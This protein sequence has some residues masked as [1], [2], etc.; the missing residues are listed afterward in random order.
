MFSIHMNDQ[1]KTKQITDWRLWSKENQVMVTVDFPSG[2]SFTKPLEACEIKPKNEIKSG[3]LSSEKGIYRLIENAV[4]YGDKYVVVN[5]PND[6]KNYVMKLENTNIV[7]SSDLK[8]ENI[9]SYFTDIVKERVRLANPNDKSM[10]ENIERQLNKVTPHK[11]T[12]LHAYCYGENQNRNPLE[13]YIFPFGLNESQLEAVENAFSS[14]ISIIEGPPG[15]GK[16]QTILNIIANI[17]INKKSVAIVSNNNGAVENVYE[18]MAKQELDYLVAKLGRSDYKKE[19]FSDLKDVPSC[20]DSSVEILIEEIDEILEK[21]KSVLAAQNKVAKLNTEISELLIE[22]KYLEEWHKE[23]SLV[24]LIDINKYKLNPE[25]TTDLLAYINHLSQTKISF[26][27]RFRLLIEFKMI[28]IKF[29]AT[30]SERINFTYSLQFHYYEKMLHQKEQQLK[31]YENELKRHHFKELLEDL[32]DKSMQYLKQHLSKTIPSTSNFT[33]DNYRKNFSKFIERFPV[34]GSSTHSIINSI[35]DGAILDYIIIDE[36]SQQD[37]VPGILSLGCAKNIIVVGDRKQLPHIPEET[38]IVAPSKYYDCSKYSL[39]DSFVELFKGDVP[40]TLLKEH[41][42]CHPKIIQFCNQQFY[43]NQLIPMTIDNGESSIQLITTAK[44][45]HTR[46]LANLREIESLVEIGWSNEKDIG[47]IAP[48]NNQVNLAG[49]YLPEEFAR[50]TI[51]KFQGRECREIIFST[52]LDKKAKDKLSVEFVDNPHLVN[53]AVSR[54]INKFTL[55]TGEEVFTKN[56]KSL[57]ALIRYIKYYAANEQIYSSPVIS[58]FDLLYEEYDRSLEK[59]NTRLD[60]MNKQVKSEKIFALVLEDILMK[61]PFNSLKYHMQIDLIQLASIKNNSFT[62]REL[63]FMRQK[64]SCDFVIY[65]KVGKNPIGV[66]EVDGSYHDE[67]ETQQER[68]QLKDSILEKSQI[69]LLRVKTREGDIE[70]KTKV[71]LN[72]CIIKSGTQDYRES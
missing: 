32:T 57:A 14:Q 36:A 40:V 16:T 21:L 12:A 24:N 2:K 58:A 39:L 7:A 62:E 48:Y 10:P 15:T 69:P 52:V 35:A 56:N 47:F 4:E 49:K 31:R 67:V 20:D 43:N 72:E 1:D 5:Y 3:L 18:K 51:H 34:I 9:F 17:L 30:Y 41:Y 6:P 11:G 70:K 42:R 8:N 63:E 65:Y 71:F 37:I 27:E 68:D 25:K 45:N 22:K 54:A 44:G 19:F 50:N 29:L 13:H 33:A 59:L 46:N 23:N 61:E 53:V 55:V 26:K 60:P 64:A 28:R 66:I 38:E